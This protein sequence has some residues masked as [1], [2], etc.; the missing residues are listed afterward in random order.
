M[1][2]RNPSRPCGA[3]HPDGDDP[4]TAAYC[5]LQEDHAGAHYSVLKGKQW[6][7]E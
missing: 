4:H 1:N 5:N 2:D 3:F 6:E 7:E